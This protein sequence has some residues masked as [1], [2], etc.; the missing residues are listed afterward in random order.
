M[1]LSKAEAALAAIAAK[2]FPCEDAITDITGPVLPRRTAFDSWRDCVH[3]SVCDL[4][5]I[6]SLES[7]LVAYIN[8]SREADHALDPID[9]EPDFSDW[10]E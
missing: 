7:R 8:A 2:E 3:D 9:Y 4:W 6:L 5:P 1:T 10:A